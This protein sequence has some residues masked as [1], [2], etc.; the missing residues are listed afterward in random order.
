MK[1]YR[2]ALPFLLAVLI[3]VFAAC[4]DDDDDATD[5]TTAPT[6]TESAPT[7]DP[8][9]L[10]APIFSCDEDYPSTEPDAAAFPVEVT[11]G[12]GRTV[13]ID[14]PPEAIISL[15][16]GHT[17]T[18]YAIGAGDQVTSVDNTS[19][20]PTAATA[21]PQID[22]YNV[23]VEAIVA[24]SPDMVILFFD[25]GDLVTTLEQQLGV[26]ILMMSAPE[27]MASIYAGIETLG[28]A[29]GHAAESADLVTAMQEQIEAVADPDAADPPTFFHE[30]DNTYYTVGPGSFI[31]DIYTLLG[32]E[33]IAAPTG[34]AFPQLDAE[35]IIQSEPDVIILAD[36]SYGE[37][38][39]TVSARAGWD[40]IPA[41]VNERVYGIDP[42]IASRPG[43]RLAELAQTLAGYL[44]E[45]VAY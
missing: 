2:Y 37:S 35:F 34:D 38:L 9:R 17:E 14:A 40:A 4:G 30:L 45:D 13:T 1:L 8:N 16:A 33:N 43:P 44:Y 22:A 26:P 42:D 29:T 24:Q 12:L 27:D 21:L 25:P 36:E 3:A 19:N 7:D 31:D 6:A 39:D 11:D 18:L 28:D 5:E 32:A 20:C 23:S 15:S 41:V 10:A